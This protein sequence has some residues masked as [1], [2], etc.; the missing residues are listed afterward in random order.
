MRYHARKTAPSVNAVSC[1]GDA[2]HAELGQPGKAEA[3]RTADRDS[4]TATPISV[5]EGMRMSPVPRT[6][7]ASVLTSQIDTAPENSTCE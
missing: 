4:M 7:E 3:E 6:T 2:A 1:R 5:A